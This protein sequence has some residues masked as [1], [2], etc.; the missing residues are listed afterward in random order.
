MSKNLIC[1]IFYKFI[2]NFFHINKIEK[3]KITN[4]I[5]YIKY[6]IINEYCYLCFFVFK[7][8]KIK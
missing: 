1:K 4:I 2:N 3:I 8:I 5:E 7:H 6:S